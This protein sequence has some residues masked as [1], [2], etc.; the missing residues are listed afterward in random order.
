[1]PAISRRARARLA[2]VAM[3][4]AVGAQ[5]PYFVLYYQLR[6]LD[7]GLIGPIVS[8][9]AVA[10]LLA[11]PAWGGVSDRLAGAPVVILGPALLA[12]AGIALLWVTTDYLAIAVGM[13]A[14]AAGMA[15]IA[16]IVEARGLET[17][18]DDRAGYGPLRAFGS[19]SFIVAAGVV[20]VGVDRWGVWAALA[21]LVLAVVVTGL[22]GLTLRPA[23]RPLI[24]D[25]PGLREI[26]ALFAV[27][28]LG[29]FLAGAALT[30]TTIAAVVGYYA[31]RF[32]EI[33]APATLVG[34]AFGLGA[35]IEVPM[36]TR[37]PWLAER[38]GANRLIV[39]GALLLAFRTLLAGVLTSAPLLVL[40]AGFGGFGFA[41]TLVGGVTFVSR[42]APPELQATA[43][44]VFQGM[45]NSVGAI[46][47]GLL[48]AAF[49]A[50]LGLGGLYVF[51]SGLGAIA[52]L[53]MGLAVTRQ[54]IPSAA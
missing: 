19:L 5:A 37:F 1:V 12:V 38:F 32:S 14:V 27:P 41:L 4:T 54:V 23:E 35:A 52:A 43:Q 15:G 44:G 50:P 7:L 31:L 39:V 47:A 2:Y 18:G 48:T 11:S 21:G 16:P 28:G 25:R 29:L 42:S 17:S 49:A 40:V 22:I 24:V 6:G 30:W 34:L 36:M 53:L 13:A 45:T 20:G 9:A 46:I 33:G 51:L 26:G 3:F 8:L 10:G